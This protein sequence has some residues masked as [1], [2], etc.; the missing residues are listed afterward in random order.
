MAWVPVRF[1]TVRAFRMDEETNG[2]ET[3]AWIDAQGRVVR[4]TSPVGF[5]MERSAF[6]IAYENFRRRD[7]ARV[8]R[9]SAQPGAGD[10]VA[11]TALAARIR[12]AP[13]AVGALRGRPSGASLPGLGIACAPHR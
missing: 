10:I 6:E 3:S 9:G 4:A 1:D 2:V 7:T 5:T 11:A 8:A 12:S 13:A